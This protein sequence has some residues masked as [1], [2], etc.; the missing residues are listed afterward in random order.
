ME[1]KEQWY[2]SDE[3]RARMPLL[4]YSAYLVPTRDVTPRDFIRG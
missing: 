1:I 3:R 2:Q 4:V